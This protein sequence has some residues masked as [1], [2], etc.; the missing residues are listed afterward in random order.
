MMG[1][2]TLDGSFSHN[3]L[4]LYGDAIEQTATLFCG[5]GNILKKIKFQPNKLVSYECIDSSHRYVKV[6]VSVV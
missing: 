6:K 1:P 2:M 5:V 4:S 3:G